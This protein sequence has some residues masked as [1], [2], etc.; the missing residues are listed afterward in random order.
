M[1][2]FVQDHQTVGEVESTL[3]S[4]VQASTEA[5]IVL[6]NTGANTTNY[7]FQEFASGVWT[8]MGTLGGDLY[9][10]LSPDEVKHIKLTSSES[11]VRLVGNASGGSILDFSV[12]RVL[13]RGD[14]GALPMLNY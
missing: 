3:F 4:M 14:G 9:S 8:D 6:Q 7:R 11:K 5:L 13:D 12:T 10:T 1:N 2:V